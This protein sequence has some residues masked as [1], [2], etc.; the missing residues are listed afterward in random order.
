MT[1]DRPVAP[2]WLGPIDDPDHPAS[3]IL[4]AAAELF[5]QRSP[6]A[7]S[8]REIAKRAGVNYGLIHHYYGT[9]DAILAELLRRGSVNGAEL[10]RDA[11]SVDDALA[12]LTTPGQRSTHA[13]ML[14]WALLDG[15][16]PAKLVAVSPTITRLT[17]LI[18]AAE[19]EHESA[20]G[21]PDPRVLAATT[22]AAILG[23][24]FFRPFIAA[25]A[26]MDDTPELSA[27]VIGLLREMVADVLQ[28]SVDPTA[29]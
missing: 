26:G 10:M 21:G 18:A 8:L 11:R 4:V 25:I 3:A 9:K 20:G 12:S 13:R 5:Q 27:D 19:A 16:D 14:A 15:V 24:N 7:V 29:T 6:S 23:W 28:E 2:P 17:E 1:D 22:V